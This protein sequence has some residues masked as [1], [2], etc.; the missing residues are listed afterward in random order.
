MRGKKYRSGIAP[1]TR[2]KTANMW[3]K[4][5]KGYRMIIPED[6]VRGIPVILNRFLLPTECIPDMEGNKIGDF[7]TV[8][9]TMNNK[10]KV[11]LI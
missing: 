2:P 3:T 1:V 6:K 9:D 7:G 11:I 8:K 4:V 5:K 10:H